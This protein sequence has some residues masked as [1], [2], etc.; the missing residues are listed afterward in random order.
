ML[1]AI[2]AKPMPQFIESLHFE[3]YFIGFYMKIILKAWSAQPD[4]A[5][6]LLY[7]TGLLSILLAYNL[8]FK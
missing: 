4:L 7:V 1:Q 2:T 6:T 3:D 5:L 8:E